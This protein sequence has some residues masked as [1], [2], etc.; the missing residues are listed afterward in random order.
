MFKGLAFLADWIIDHRWST[1]FML[2]IWTGL[3]TVGHVDPYLILPEP[4][5]YSAE[6]ASEKK[7]ESEFNRGPNGP[8]PNVSPV[9][10]AA[11]HVV[12]VAECDEFFTPS[13]A[14]AIRAAVEAIEALPQ[15]REVTWMDRAP[16][17]NIFGLPE[18]ILPNRHASAARFEAA[19]ERALEHPLVG[20]QMLSSD[21]KT[22]LLLVNLDWLYVMENS[23]C[24]DAL[25]DTAVQATQAFDEVS[26]RFRVTGEVP[27]RVSRAANNRENER[28]Y[29]LIGYSIALIMAFI[30]FR[31]ISA[32]IIVALAPTFGVFWTL[33]VLH[34]VGLDDNPFN[35]VIVPVLLCMVGFTDGVHMMVQI[36]RHRAAGMSAAEAARLSIREVGLACW[37][38]SLT[39]AIG[40][41]SLWLAHHELVREFGYCCVI[42]VLLTFISVVTIIPLACASPLGRRV[43]TGYGRNLIDKNLSRISVIIDYVLKHSLAFSLSA[44]L[45]TLGL[46]AMTLQLRPDQRLTSNL[47]SRAEAT[48]ALAHIDRT[49]GG[50]ETSN[51]VV[52]WHP[53][54]PSNSG[55][56]AVILKEVHDLLDKEPLIGNPMS[57]VRL[58]DALPGEGDAKDRMSLLELLPPPL[59]RAYY[60]PEHRDAK[61]EFRLQDIGIAS[62]GPAFER[63]EEGLSRIRQ[64]H[65]NF[66]LELSGSA[67]HRWRDLYRV[68]LDL[69]Y[70]L[71][72]ASVIIFGVLTLVYRSL[73][74]G[75]ISIIPNIFPLAATGFL[76]WVVGMHLEIVSVCAFTVCLG[77]AVD[78]T[79]H[80][81]TRYREES[82]KSEGDLHHAIRQSFIG[83][84]T[85]LIMTTIVL[86][87]GFATALISD[88]R[89]H[90]IFAMMGILTI[91]SALFGDLVFLPALLL[92]YA[93]SPTSK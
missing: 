90:Q 78:D 81:L 10:V 37:L 49:F 3:M 31:G 18:P 11:G 6:E 80:F 59:K 68:V 57:I 2:A 22:M 19:K 34:F 84:G 42:G 29:Q 77:I 43:H 71:G 73:R 62:Y 46:A 82:E 35:S 27:I 56:I 72:T 64:S 45:I 54:V 60:A 66:R 4:G 86:I 38:T 24:T 69:S 33:G 74:L 70:S 16:P 26:I 40:F 48:R 9:Q 8:V 79:I 63:I 47:G 28:K 1:L 13:G 41:G 58:I 61:V 91:G 67:V 32:V 17:L 7:A 30:L 36:R 51:V 55:E 75:L 65:P 5:G 76:L 83:V 85:A 89:D 12:V 23:D 92:R 52:K 25:R 87:I 88:A 39:T 93:R 15:V 53:D 14:E 44:V 50:M 21:T 20:G